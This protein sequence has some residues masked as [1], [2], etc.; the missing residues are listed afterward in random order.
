MIE[1][2]GDRAQ[3]LVAERADTALQAE[4]AIGFEEWCL[5]AKALALLTQPKRISQATER[6]S[7]EDTLRS[8]ANDVVAQPLRRAQTS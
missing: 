8:M 2:F 4:D 3:F 1:D 7:G 6:N 5:V